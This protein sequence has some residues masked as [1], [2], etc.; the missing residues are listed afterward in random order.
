LHLHAALRQQQAAPPLSGSNRSLRRSVTGPRSASPGRARRPVRSQNRPV[1]C[2]RRRISDRSQEAA[3]EQRAEAEAVS[4]S[5][6]TPDTATGNK[7][8]PVLSSCPLSLPFFLIHLKQSV[9]RLQTQSNSNHNLVDQ[10]FECL[11]YSS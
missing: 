6:P 9:M 7:I 2:R 11:V 1:I 4:A 10:P 5:I 3:Q 8:K